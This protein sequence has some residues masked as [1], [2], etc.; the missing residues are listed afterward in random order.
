[1]DR[2][3]LAAA[4]YSTYLVMLLVS[5]FFA[6][7]LA[8]KCR[9]CVYLSEAGMSLLVGFL[10][11]GLI[12]LLVREDA[13]DR[14]AEKELRQTVV[15]FSSTVLLCVLLPPIIFDSGF[16]M[17][18]SRGSRRFGWPQTGE[19]NIDKIAVLAFAGTL[20]SSLIVGAMGE[21][22]HEVAA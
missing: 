15:G 13:S 22:W 1:M 2:E 21:F 5:F 18:G 9:S 19:A 8:Q 4:A 11:G 6:Y 12:E 16:R 20:I 10:G 17:R 3:S 7:C 14:F